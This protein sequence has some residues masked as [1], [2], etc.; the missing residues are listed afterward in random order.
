MLE[1]PP[2]APAVRRADAAHRMVP[3][4]LPSGDQFSRERRTNH[5]AP[6]E[7]REVKLGVEV[8]TAFMATED[9][10]LN[11]D[12]ISH[13]GPFAIVTSLFAEV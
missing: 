8:Q 9:S 5:L 13:A 2:A 1:S 3:F 10:H 4:G 12:Q 7:Q 11:H 6:P